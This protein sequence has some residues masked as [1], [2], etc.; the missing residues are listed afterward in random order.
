MIEY[1]WLTA[2]QAQA[3]LAALC[4]VLDGCVAGGASIGFIARDNETF[5][6]F[7]QDMTLSLACGDRQL[8]VARLQGRIVATVMLVLAMPGNGQHR[9]ELV[10]L[11]VHPSARRRGIAHELMYRAEQRAREAGRSLLVL[12]TRSG[13]VA[14]SLYRALGW[15]VAGQIPGYARSV[16]GVMDATTV[17]YKPLSD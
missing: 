12:D 1:Q 7:W 9:A 13:D 6:R 14:E 11:L 15:Q 8:L 16:E 5:L 17:M 3:E 4:E 10:K 2:Q